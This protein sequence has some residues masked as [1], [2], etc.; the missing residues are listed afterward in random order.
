MFTVVR[1]VFIDVRF[2]ASPQ[3]AY[4]SLQPCEFA[5]YATGL[6]FVIGYVVSI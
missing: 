6:D 5:G 3:C 2:E 1:L 4:R